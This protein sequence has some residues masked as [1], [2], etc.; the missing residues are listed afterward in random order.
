MDLAGSERLSK[1][2]SDEVRLE[3][4]KI[5]NKSIS[6]L[7]NCIAALVK[8][9]RRSKNAIVF[10]KS[11]IPF[12]DS[13]LTRILSESLCGNSKTIIIACIS[14]NS[15]NHDESISTLLFASRAMQIEINL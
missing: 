6:A 12:R 2:F 10:N 5:I 4:A 9:N 11:F 1:T 13:K 3:E 15:S 8:E 14:P 7:G